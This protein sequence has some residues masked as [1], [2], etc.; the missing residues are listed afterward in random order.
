MSFFAPLTGMFSS[1]ASASISFT[2][3]SS[4]DVISAR[5]KLMLTSESYATV[6]KSTSSAA[7][8]ALTDLTSASIQNFNSVFADERE[9]LEQIEPFVSNTIIS[10]QNVDIQSL[11]NEEEQKSISYG[12]QAD[13]QYN[14]LLEAKKRLEN[15]IVSIAEKVASSRKG[16]EGYE[17]WVEKLTRQ[18]NILEKIN[19]ASLAQGQMRTTF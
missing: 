4:S 17:V 11:L 12:E 1:S 7:N 14:S 9:T 2:D 13:Q 16:S 18:M 8:D 10:S 3:I 6:E 15:E 5:E 19:K